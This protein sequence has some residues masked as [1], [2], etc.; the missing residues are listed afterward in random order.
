MCVCVCVWAACFSIK[1]S[2][3]RTQ[4]FQT[5]CVT[6]G[7]CNYLSW[8]QEA[9]LCECNSFIVLYFLCL[10]PSWISTVSSFWKCWSLP[11]ILWSLRERIVS[12]FSVWSL[13]M[14][15]PERKVETHS[16]GK[17]SCLQQGFSSRE[18]FCPCSNLGGSCVSF[19]CGGFSL[20]WGL[21]VLCLS[22][23]GL[24]LV[25]RSKQQAHLWTSSAGGWMNMGMPVL[26]AEGHPLSE[27]TFV[28]HLMSWR[29]LACPAFS[30]AFSQGEPGSDL[31]NSCAENS[32]LYLWDQQNHS[33]SGL[34][35]EKL[36]FLQI[37]TVGSHSSVLSVLH[38]A[39]PD[40]LW[41]QNLYWKK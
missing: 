23:P 17:V 9:L 26:G 39:L 21:W 13:S 27:E 2:L 10:F 25:T 40:I 22:P 12:Y 8:G 37:R 38:W 34:S 36:E 33:F 7:L 29:L 18:L 35:L 11:A 19:V 31:F 6:N 15:G 32:W 28:C 20:A 24:L 16:E 30:E 41:L 14:L 3:F 4:D 5:E 1:Q